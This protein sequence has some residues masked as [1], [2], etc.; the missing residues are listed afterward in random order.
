METTPWLVV[1]GGP[2]GAG[3]TTFARSA[4]ASW[5]LP[6]LSADLVVEEEGLGT[7][8]AQAFRAGRLFT[9]RLDAAVSR[10]QSLFVESTL[11]GVGFG[12]LV[13]RARAGGY[14]V[15]LEFV[16]V[17]SAE[18]C[19]RRIRTR[20]RRGGHFVPDRDVRRRFR[21]S[22]SNLWERYRFDADAWYLTYNGGRNAIRVAF[23][24][25]QRAVVVDRQWFER[26]LGLLEA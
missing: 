7:G 14:R 23:G 20:A 17:E 25:G 26:F 3:K 19:I 12:R 2:N 10:G 5:S 21:R 24:N 18:T 13:R 8:G 4:A 15:S 11:S 22:L 16:F 9:G 1:V 6:Y